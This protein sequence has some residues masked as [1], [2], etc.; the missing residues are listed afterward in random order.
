VNDFIFVE[1][2]FES[3]DAAI[4]I[5]KLAELGNDFRQVGKEKQYY[6]TR[7]TELVS[8]SGNINSTT[9]SAL[10]L[11]DEFLSK[12]MRVSYIPAALKNSYRQ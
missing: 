6:G 11:Q 5:K 12:R 7:G 4:G 10:K 9:A 8:V 2:M 3:F 1:F